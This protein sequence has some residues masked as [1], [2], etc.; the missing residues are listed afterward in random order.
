MRNTA[1]LQIGGQVAGWAVPA[2]Q[3]AP[4]AAALAELV[5]DQ[6]AERVELP[7]ELLARPWDLMSRN[8]AR[9]AADAAAEPDADHRARLSG[10]HVLGQQRIILE[11]G[12][13]VEPGVVLDVRAG[14]VWLARRTRVEGPARAT[15][16]L[17]LG[18]D[19]TILGGP[20][21]TS[22]IGPV[23]RVRG[24]V[25][26]SVILG[27]SNK[28]HDG[29]LGHALL[30]RWVNLGADTINSDLKNTY[31][32]VHVRLPKGNVNS[33]LIKVGCFIGD[34]VKTGIGTLIGTGAVIGAASNVF[35]GRMP[36]PY[37][38]PFSW[39]AG[40]EL[41]EYR[42]DRF[43]ATAQ[44][45]MSRRA[46]ELTPGMRQVLTQAWERSRGERANRQRGS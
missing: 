4:S 35:G 30:G 37:V 41:V 32:A 16:P 26:D 28:A 18:P 10:V 40:D 21:S 39:G 11:E 36:P 6:A 22:S 1:T 15:G 5:P 14:P 34:H 29:H 2:G 38:P 8:A 23:C 27:Y 31:S 42:L 45:A 3:P 33:G 25:I 12:A 43:L 19:S 17:Y 46:V 44:S 13:V 20:V 7:G 9:I 24:E